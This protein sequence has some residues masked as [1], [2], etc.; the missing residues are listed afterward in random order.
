MPAPSFYS[1]GL[2]STAITRALA[3]TYFSTRLEKDVWD[4]F[5]IG[6]RDKSIV[7]AKDIITRALGNTV[8][9]ETTD[10]DTNYYPDRAVYHQALFM[11]IN[12]DHTANGE[13]TAPKW[14]GATKR[15]ES[16][17]K[18]GRTVAKEALLWMNWRNGSTIKIARG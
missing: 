5:S 11:L 16:R 4:A 12:S 8:T 1:G 18:S 2:M 9:E 7:S 13:F 10:T 14:P 17:D 6:L 15:I 3:D